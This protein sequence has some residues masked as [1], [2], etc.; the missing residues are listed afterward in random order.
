MGG[1]GDALHGLWDLSFLIEPGCSAV[2]VWSPNDWT[3]REFPWHLMLKLSLH[4]CPY[5][6]VLISS[7]FIRCQVKLHSV[8]QKSVTRSHQTEG[9]IKESNMYRA[10][11]YESSS[12]RLYSKCFACVTVVNLPYDPRRDTLIM[13]THF[14]DEQSETNGGEAQTLRI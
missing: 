8:L 3:A 7:I 5:V 14:M 2:K 6:L 10:T 9:K 1:G 11:D 13:L 4:H 12:A